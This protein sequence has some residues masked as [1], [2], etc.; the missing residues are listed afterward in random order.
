MNRNTLCKELETKGIPKDSYNLYGGLPNEAYCL[1][2]NNEAGRYIIA[3]E[4]VN[5]V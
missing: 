3:K 2:Q 4:A 1:N 5:L